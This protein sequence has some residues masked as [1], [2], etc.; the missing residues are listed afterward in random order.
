[1]NVNAIQTPDGISLQSVTIN[2]TGVGT[3]ILTTGYNSLS[4][5]LTGAEGGQIQ[6]MGSNDNVVWSP[7]LLIATD[8]LDV[9]DTIQNSGNYSL[10][11]STLYVRYSCV[12]LVGTPTF[13]VVGRIGGGPDAA[14]KLALAMNPENQYPLNFNVMSGLK[15]DNQNALVPSDCKG[16]YTSTLV[17]DTALVI[18]TTGYNS[19][20]VQIIVTGFTLTFQCS[21]DGVNWVNTL[22][23][24]Q[25]GSSPSSTNSTSGVYIVQCS[26]RFLKL[27][28]VTG[29]PSPIIV[30][31]RNQP[32]NIANSNNAVVNLTLINSITP[33]TPGLTGAFGV[34]GTVAPG[35]V[36]GALNPVGVAGA[37]DTNKARRLQT[38]ATGRLQLASQLAALG[39]NTTP[40]IAVQDVTLNEGQLSTDILMQILTELRIL[41]QQFYEVTFDLAT[42]QDS[43]DTYRSDP[44]QFVNN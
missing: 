11:V 25:G 38:D 17:T 16:P 7:L 9:I 22:L 6:L 2:A 27:G 12:T 35:V 29:G 18:D 19:A 34:G 39:L 8:S 21:N 20:I 4:I 31:L 1:M 43:P 26:G 23:Y 44:N 41:N 10:K 13:T 15:V 28:G 37:D 42:P 24:S 5:S 30:Y 32:F 14:D 3:S 40:S 36:S 33:V